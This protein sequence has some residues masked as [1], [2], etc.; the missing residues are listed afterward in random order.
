MKIP[1][2][3]LQT[4]GALRVPKTTQQMIHFVALAYVVLEKTYYFKNKIIT[5]TLS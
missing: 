4:H 2:S 3:T 5:T 1:L